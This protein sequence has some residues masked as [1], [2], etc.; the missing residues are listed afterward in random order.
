MRILSRDLQRVEFKYRRYIFVGETQGF[1][2]FVLKRCYKNLHVI[3]FL[4]KTLV[5]LRNVKEK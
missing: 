2:V 5:Q 1:H 4:S 3:M